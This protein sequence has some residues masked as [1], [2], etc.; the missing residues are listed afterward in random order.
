MFITDPNECSAEN[1]SHLLDG[2]GWPVSDHQLTQL[3]SECFK[4]YWRLASDCEAPEAD[5]LLA[6][7]PA[8]V[9]LLNLL[10][11]NSAINWSERES[12]DSLGKSREY[13]LSRLTHPDTIF[14][15]VHGVKEQ[16][17]GFSR[18]LFTTVQQARRFRAYP[19][20]DARPWQSIALGFPGSYL[21][22]EYFKREKKFAIWGDGYVMSFG[23]R[24]IAG[25]GV[26][27]KTQ[28]IIID[29]VNELFRISGAASDGL[30][31]DR[32]I[33]GWIGRVSAIQ[34]LFDQ[35]YK[36]WWVRGSTAKQLHLFG[37]GNICRKVFG[38]ASQRAG[39]TV[40]NYLEKNTF[41]NIEPLAHV[42]EERLW[43]NTFCPNLQV[44][45]AREQNYRDVIA[46]RHHKTQRYFSVSSSHFHKMAQWAGSESRTQPKYDVVIVGFP[47][48][49]FRYLDDPSLFFYFRLRLEV[50]IIRQLRDLGL[51]VAY[52]VH[53][54]RLLEGHIKLLRH[55]GAGV[56][57]EPFEEGHEDARMILFTHF[58]TSVLGSAVASGK[59]IVAF[60]N[61][62]AALNTVAVGALYERVAKVEYTVSNEGR[63]EYS[64]SCLEEALSNACSKRSDT[65]FLDMYL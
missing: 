38:L 41:L 29:L 33:D 8:V 64:V 9:S 31:R 52:S 21:R 45:R 43:E 53:T 34:S 62:E 24:L 6:D 11:Y 40:N 25:R 51:S 2:P 61:K 19:K 63:P 16:V 7:A 20:V 58:S 27:Q 55:V 46:S 5:L 65:Q 44:I 3:A 14:G 30:P 1:L 37:P 57:T 48:V 13:F 12:M 18:V 10:Q 60:V 28:D 35:V 49:H 39:I 23:N 54:E 17:A 32:I 26:K 42:F 36:S 22:S 50:Q 4:I 56:I 15:S 59:P 47:L